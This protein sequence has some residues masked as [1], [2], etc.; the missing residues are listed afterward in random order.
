MK[1]T[2]DG[3]HTVVKIDNWICYKMDT[4]N[5]IG[6]NIIV[7]LTQSVLQHCVTI[8]LNHLS[9]RVERLSRGLASH[10]GTHR[11]PIFC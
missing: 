7:S 2:E 1:E 10:T 4:S 11:G 3:Q 8:G 5:Y 6:G 9:R